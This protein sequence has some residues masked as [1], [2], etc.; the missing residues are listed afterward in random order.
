[1]VF[2]TFQ[3]Y[4]SLPSRTPWFQDVLSTLLLILTDASQLCW[5]SWTSHIPRMVGDT[6]LM[7]L[8][9]VSFAC[10]R[11]LEGSLLD[12]WLVWIVVD[13]KG[14]FWQERAVGNC[15]ADFFFFFC[16]DRF[17]DLKLDGTSR[18][19]GVFVTVRGSQLRTN[20]KWRSLFAVT[21]YQMLTE[22]QA[23]F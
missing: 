6:M 3:S 19:F 11:S 16:K 20:G 12:L 9:F 13:Q 7:A 15:W 1:M 23:V 18:T 17:G 8:F 10:S 2:L 14:N 22:L 4:Q 21:V 5:V